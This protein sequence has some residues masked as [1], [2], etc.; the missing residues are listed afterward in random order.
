MKHLYSFNNN[1]NNNNTNY[2]IINIITNVLLKL[3]NFHLLY[4]KKVLKKSFQLLH[5]N[6]NYN[7]L[8]IFMN[9]K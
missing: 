9:H 7:K 1:Y 3:L 8:S 5:K 6:L 4:A 2:L